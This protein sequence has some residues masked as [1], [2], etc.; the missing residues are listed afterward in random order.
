MTETEIRQ[1]MAKYT[2]Y[3]SIKLTENI[4]TPGWAEV[5]PGNIMLSSLRALDLTPCRVTG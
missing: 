2:F 4:T 3:H 1:E 5:V